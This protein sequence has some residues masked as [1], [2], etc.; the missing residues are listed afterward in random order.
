MKDLTLIFALIA[1]CSTLFANNPNSG[2][3]LKVIADSGLKMRL[4]PGLSGDVIAVIPY[5]EAVEIL[6][7]PTEKNVLTSDFVSGEWV[8]V[9]YEGQAGY[10]FDGYLTSLPIPEYDFELNENEQFLIHNVEAYAD[11]RYLSTQAADSTSFKNGMTK[12]VQE[13]DNGNK[14]TKVYDYDFFKLE[15]E[16]KQTRVMDAYHLLLSMLPNDNQKET[17]MNQTVFL[18]DEEGITKRVNIALE[19]PITIVRLPN[20][21]IKLKLVS[22]LEGC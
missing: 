12:V 9:S 15:L 16:L 7:L 19:N 11:F 2:Q 22:H 3:T 18:A 13:Y 21:N 17:L 20:G 1:V 8:L 14:M 10:V 6:E 4:S 5:A